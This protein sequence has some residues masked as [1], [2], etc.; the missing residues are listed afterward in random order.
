MKRRDEDSVLEEDPKDRSK[1]C[2]VCGESSFNEI[3]D[4]CKNDL[5]EDADA[6]G[7]D[8]DWEEEES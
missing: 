1:L 2:S 8:V 5:G 7:D 3:C 6:E 4:D